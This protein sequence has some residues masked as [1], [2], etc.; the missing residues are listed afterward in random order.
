MTHSYRTSDNFGT[1]LFGNAV[2]VFIFIFHVGPVS[3]RFGRRCKKP[4]M[5][6]IEICLC[7]LLIYGD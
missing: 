5:L 7:L 4:L 3:S 6:D 1:E 2:L